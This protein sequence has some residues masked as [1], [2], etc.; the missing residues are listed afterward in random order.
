M[1]WDDLLTLLEQGEGP[2]V[3]FEKVIPSEED[4][5]RDMVAFAN[6]G[7]GKIVFGL[8]D[9]NKHLIGVE[10]DPNFEDWIKQI[11]KT[12]S[13]P[14]LNPSVDVIDKAGKKIVVISVP[15]GD[16]RPYR[17]DEICY[18]RDGNLSRPAKETEEQDL[19]NPWSGKGLNKRQIRAMQMVI[20]HGSIT[21]R[22]YREAFNVSHKTA[23]I[24]LT[25]L[26]DKNLVVTEGAGRS[27]RYTPPPAPEE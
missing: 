20:E 5:A 26:A 15:E 16:D 14:G 24:E 9:K 7:G 4:I 10:V 19:I 12:R 25:L 1:T 11:A 6:T 21:N 27:T 17:S 22:E 13:V 18:I 8:D 3:E 2:S 23:H